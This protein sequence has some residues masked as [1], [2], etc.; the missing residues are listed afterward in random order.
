MFYRH[1]MR[2]IRQPHAVTHLGVAIALASLISG[3]TPTDPPTKQVSASTPAA[4]FASD[5]EALAAARKTYEEF[6]AV[7]KLVVNEGGVSPERIVALASPEIAAVEKDGIAASAGRN[8]AITG[9]SVVRNSVLQSYTPQVDGGRGIITS[10]FCIDV[11]GVD[12]MDETGASVVQSSR[13]DATPFVV[14]FD[15]VEK[16]SPRLIV[17]AKNVWD[18]EGVC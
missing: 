17:S 11:S 7:T 6:M 10:Y 16:Q 18:G 4:P 1:G 5:E 14:V 2:R 8:L 3:C 12:V 9:S 15:L 13:P